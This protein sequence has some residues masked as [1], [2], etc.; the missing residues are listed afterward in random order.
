[1]RTLTPVF[2]MLILG[3][4]VLAS[5]CN[6]KSPE[7]HDSSVESSES[8]SK[9]AQAV[10]AEPPPPPRPDPLAS[11]D[12]PHIDAFDFLVNR[13]NAHRVEVIDGAQA[14]VVDASQR[15]FV[16]YIHGNHP[17]EWKLEVDV[18]GV[19]SAMLHK[20]RRAMIWAPS[21]TQE[22][23]IQLRVYSPVSSNTLEI[24]IGNETFARAELEKGWQTVTLRS[25]AVR[26]SD[27]V[28]MRIEFS[29]MG[30]IEGALSGGAIEWIRL[31][32]AMEASVEVELASE[33]Q[34]SEGA[35]A[36]S[37]GGQEL[38]ESK[39]GEDGES[40]V[41]EG[42]EE[43][44]PTPT[45]A[46]PVSSI[47]DL[48]TE[49]GPLKLGA[50]VMFT[51]W[52]LEEAKLD[53]TIKAEPG[54]GLEIE[55]WKEDGAGAA[56][57]ALKESR[58]LVETY[59]EEQSTFVD[60]SELKG[61]VV[62]TVFR[63]IECGAVELKRASLVV[64]GEPVAI[65]D[66]EPPKYIVFWLIDTLRADYLPIH[67][68]TN[69]EAPN[70]QRLAAEGTSFKLAYVQGNESKT[71]HASL[72]SGM[73]PSAHGVVGRGS[74]RP[75]HTI[76][77]E[78]LKNA[79]Y[80]TGAYIS[81][82]YVS[83]PWGFVQGWDFY[84]NNLREN[85]R[86]DGMSMQKMG[87]KWIRDNLE[88]EKLFLYLG[89]IDPHVTYRRH[90]GIIEKY[91]TEPYTGR[92]QRACYGEDLGKIK[93]GSLKVTERDKLRIINL[94]KN[95]IDFNDQAFG[96][97]RKALEEAGVWD[98]TM[99]V[100]TSDH[101]DEFWEHGSVGHGHSMYQ[102]QV[103]VP[104]MF[105]Y[106]PLIPEGTVVEAGADVLD[107]YPTLLDIVGG[108]RPKGMQGKSL[109]DVMYKTKGDYPEP[110]SAT[111]YKIH[112]AMQLQHWKLYLRRGQFQMFDRIEDHL[113]MEDVADSHPVASRW[114]LDSMGWLRAHRKTWDKSVHG[115]PSNLS[116]GFLENTDQLELD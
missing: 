74:L 35:D 23:V 14:V 46:A 3:G 70:L 27:E 112:Y 40:D 71:S 6:S 28:A 106:P 20:K 76:M 91:D 92:F 19:R 4:G 59:G 62:R 78:G 94:Y 39:G 105:Y 63:P 10:K 42:D 97:L 12:A 48:T 25:D 81:N 58:R 52:V 75:H 96:E 101:G 107:V 56:I 9:A 89:T 47:R 1:M 57:P 86:I 88:R 22:P 93:G 5:G 30:R 11:L 95:E 109:V 54:C 26:L 100:V 17:N 49:S 18:D 108:E 72:F 2:L 33:S 68:E 53:L 67:F 55:V 24:G 102:D 77:P 80:Y 115:V 82:G 37:D 84:L 104:L 21:L 36:G 41:S 73:F 32:A 66:V 43:E 114:L 31:G 79:G 64:P 34:P 29:N 51:H 111:Q 44:P 116:D 110:A 38:A 98:E 16:R 61:Q 103:H 7:K 83:K 90:D 8:S 60:L 13:P 50:P 85:Y 45:I 99:V 87:A 65:P 15:D 113:E 69:V